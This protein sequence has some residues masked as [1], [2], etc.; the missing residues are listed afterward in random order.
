MSVAA[1]AAKERAV[2]VYSARRLTLYT[3]Q[4]LNSKLRCHQPKSDENSWN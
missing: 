2:C 1:G 4:I 3:I